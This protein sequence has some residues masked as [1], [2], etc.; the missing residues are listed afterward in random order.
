MSLAPSEP[1]ISILLVDDEKSIRRI[2]ACSLTGGKESLAAAWLFDEGGREDLEEELLVELTSLAL[3][4]LK[5]QVV[6]HG[7]QG[8]VVAG[9]VLDQR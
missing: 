6:G 4:P 9:S 8:A 7:H 2:L 5:E 1:K 3:R